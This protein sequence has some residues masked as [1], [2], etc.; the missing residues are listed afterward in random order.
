MRGKFAKSTQIITELVTII[1]KLSYAA[2]AESNL[3]SAGLD[4]GLGKYAEY[5]LL[6][7]FI[8]M[9]VR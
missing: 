7:S 9:T 3:H 2:A 8:G 5:S 6:I 1:S 4:L